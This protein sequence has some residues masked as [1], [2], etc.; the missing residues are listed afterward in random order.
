[1]AS[2]HR[3]WQLRLSGFTENSCM[4]ST[5]SRMPM[6]LQKPVSRPPD[7]KLIRAHAYEAARLSDLAAGVTTARLKVRIS[8]TPTNLHH[9]A[10]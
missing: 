8:I 10:R 2:V 9:S 4:A 5:F 6:R 7:E 1:M 3:R